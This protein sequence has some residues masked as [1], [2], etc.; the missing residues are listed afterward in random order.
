MPTRI[1]PKRHF[2]NLLTATFTWMRAHPELKPHAFRILRL[3]PGLERR[4]L[5]FARGNRDL[6]K[7][8]W[9]NSVWA[10]DADPHVLLEWKIIA[11][12]VSHISGTHQQ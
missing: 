12:Q 11:N 5:Q 7:A 3:I 2:L 10:I 6:H 4:F 9:P 8:S 1:W